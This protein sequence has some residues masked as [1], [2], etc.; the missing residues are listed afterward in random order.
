MRV[1]SSFETILEYSRDSAL[2]S[3]AEDCS[4]ENNKYET[5]K[6]EQPEGEYISDSE[7]DSSV[8]AEYSRDRYDY[9]VYDQFVNQNEPMITNDYTGNY[10]FLVD[11]NA[12]DVKP[13]LSSSCV[14]LS[15][16]E[17]TII[18]DQSLISRGQEDDQSSCRET[19][20]AEQE[21]TM[22]MQLFPEEQHVSYFLV[23]SQN[24]PVPMVAFCGG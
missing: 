23:S 13:I 4:E 12:Y 11:Q 22:D 6:G 17:V 14:H 9:E 10:M 19:I 2:S 24:E 21:V 18:D 8:C 5:D 3:S 1:M 15:E 16:K 20:M 7:S